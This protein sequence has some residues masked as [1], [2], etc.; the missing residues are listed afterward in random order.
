MV[1]DFSPFNLEITDT[2]AIDCFYNSTCL[3][4]QN[5]T[6]GDYNYSAP[7]FN[8]TAEYLPQVWLGLGTAQVL[9][10]DNLDNMTDTLTYLINNITDI[11]NQIFSFKANFVEEI[12]QF[13]IDYNN[14][15]ITTSGLSPQVIQEIIV[16]LNNTNSALAQEFDQILNNAFNI[17]S[18]EDLQQVASDYLFFSNQLQNIV[19]VVQNEIQTKEAALATANSNEIMNSIQMLSANYTLLGQNFT[20]EF[21]KYQQVQDNYTNIINNLLQTQIVNKF[22]FTDP[23]VTTAVQQ[24]L[25]NIIQTQT[26]LVNNTWTQFIAQF[27]KYSGDLNGTII[28]ETILLNASLQNFSAYITANSTNANANVDSIFTNSSEMQALFVWN[29]TITPVQTLNVM[30]TA[31]FADALNQFQADF[32]IFISTIEGN[33]SS[34]ASTVTNATFDSNYTI[35]VTQIMNFTSS[36]NVSESVDIQSIW[37]DASTIQN[38]VNNTIPNIL[39]NS[40]VMSSDEQQR[41]LQ[42]NLFEIGINVAEVLNKFYVLKQAILLNIQNLSQEI[43]ASDN[44][45]LN[46][47]GLNTTIVTNDMIQ[48]LSSL[49]NQ[50]LVEYI[51]N[52]SNFYGILYQVESFLGINNVSNSSNSSCNM[53]NSS[54][55]SSGAN[56]SN[57]SNSSGANMSNS[58]GASMSNSTN[59]SGAN[60][61]GANSSSANMSNSTNSS[62]NTSNSTNGTQFLSDLLSFSLQEVAQGIQI[63]QAILMNNYSNLTLFTPCEAIALESRFANC[64]VGVN[65]FTGLPANF[66]DNVTIVLSNVSVYGL[67]NFMSVEIDFLQSVNGS[68]GNAFNV[69]GGAFFF[70]LDPEISISVEIIENLTEFSFLSYNASTTTSGSGNMSNVLLLRVLT[71]NEDLIVAANVIDVDVDES[72]L[73]IVTAQQFINATTNSLCNST[74]NV[75]QNVTTYSWGSPMINQVNFS[76]P[77]EQM[78]NQTGYVV[79]VTEILN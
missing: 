32:L 61:S 33:S 16:E 14:S 23:S 60:S 11:Y 2:M 63:I 53:S 49:I 66:S 59:S 38:I 41:L 71:M 76:V 34:N 13:L 1:L 43:I 31:A 26:N 65:N 57:S 20:T 28:N 55:S 35:L 27:Q 21:N 39:N 46:T 68:Y 30:A 56:A 15:N 18:G 47:T 24:F 69:S 3:M 42:F 51:L 6:V 50:T 5:I 79:N 7:T 75:C 78:T 74:T 40:Y 12:N 45:T 77:A 67:V 37:T 64:S 4:S 19:Q 17:L 44:L 73:S 58:S 36:F 22:N 48:N 10:L 54:N 29:H 70:E 9:L 25:F 8:F 62:A 52:Q 72:Y